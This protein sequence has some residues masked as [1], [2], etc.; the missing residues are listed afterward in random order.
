MRSQALQYGPEPNILW[1]GWADDLES[2]RAS[3]GQ[4]RRQPVTVRQRPGGARDRPFDSIAAPSAMCAPDDGH[5]RTRI[6]GG[7]FT[8][9]RALDK[10]FIRSG[11]PAAHVGTEKGS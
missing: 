2:L 9:P 11:F 10:T 7:S 4:R 6:N 1:A 5:R 3:C 8:I